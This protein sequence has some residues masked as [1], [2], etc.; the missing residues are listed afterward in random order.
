MKVKIPFDENKFADD[1][2]YNAK[3]LSLLED[4]ENI[5]LTT[6][7][8]FLDELDGI[9]LP[10]KYYNWQI[11]ACIELYNWQEN[12]G[13]KAYSENG[14][15]WSREN[16]GTLSSALMDELVPCAGVPKRRNNIDN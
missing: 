10:K 8:P 6:L 7:Y 1:K 2:Q 4:S 14:L 9:T 3:L 5:A 16:D 12:A 15:N 11:R 13:V